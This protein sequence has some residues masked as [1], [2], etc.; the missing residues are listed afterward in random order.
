MLYDKYRKIKNKTVC[1]IQSILL[2]SNYNKNE[3]R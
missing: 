3:S 2:Y 1:N